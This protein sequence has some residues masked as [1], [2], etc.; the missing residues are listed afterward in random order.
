VNWIALA[1]TA[2][3][4]GKAIHNY[5]WG[6]AAEE[7][8]KRRQ[9]EE[10][11]GA[12][13]TSTSIVLDAVVSIE[14]NRLRGDVNGFLEIFDT[15]DAGPGEEA[16]LREIADNSA[17]T[18]ANLAAN[19]TLLPLAGTSMEA[20]DKK[21][22][23]ILA[24]ESAGL[25]VPLVFLRV[26]A[27]VERELT[28]GAKEIKDVPGVLE[29][30]ISDLSPVP[31]KL[32]KSSDSRFGPLFTQNS[33]EHGLRLTWHAYLFNGRP[34]PCSLVRIA[35]SRAISESSR[36]SR[37]NAEYASYEGGAGPAISQA[38]EQMRII[39]DEPV[40]FRQS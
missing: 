5:G 29:Q 2:L 12:I 1:S 9:L 27:L 35:N 17:R 31:A 22:K 26:Q 33:E 38:M 11:L 14:I 19:I 8:E 18:V 3:E 16:R 6:N 34:V 39:R 24:L 20:A 37:M 15:Y 21:F 32:R 23:R 4:I 13:R 28:Y 36:R 10:I 7:A 25:M 30:A 40:P